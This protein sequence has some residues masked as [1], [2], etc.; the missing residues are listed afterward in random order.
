MARQARSKSQEPNPQLSE[1]ARDPGEGNMPWGVRAAKAMSSAQSNRWTYIALLGGSDTLAFRLRTAQGHLRRDMFPSYWSES[2]L[3]QTQ[4]PSLENARAIHVPLAQPEGPK[5]STRDNGVVSRPLSDFDDAARFPNI[6]LIALPIAQEQILQRVR[7]FCASRATL[8]T[9]EHVLRWLAYAWGVAR[10]GNPLHENY[11]LPSACMLET[12][13]AAASFD[14]TPGLEARASCPEAIW[15]AAKHWYEYFAQAH[16]NMPQGRYWHP[17]MYPITEA[18][19]DENPPGVVEPPPA[20][21]K[22]NP[23]RA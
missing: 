4:G 20:T 16:G 21:R 11:G 9:L 3:I 18:P 13:C 10:T 19:S 15:S 23:R 14:L 22:R 12:V 6:A 7:D 2:I 1:F 8:D 5:F 17:H